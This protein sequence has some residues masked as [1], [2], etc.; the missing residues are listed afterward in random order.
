MEVVCPLAVDVT[1]GPGRRW[2][3]PLWSLLARFARR[4]ENRK[5]KRPYLLHADSAR[6]GRRGR[7]LGWRAEAPLLREDAGGERLITLALATCCELAHRMASSRP[8]SLKRVCHW[9]V[10]LLMILSN[11][12]AS[13][14]LST[15]VFAIVGRELCAWGIG[16]C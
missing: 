9:R 6:E 7:S 8:F 4:G 11:S 13:F 12:A 2:G 14:A 15:F 1:R 10:P 3:Y 16:C 5:A